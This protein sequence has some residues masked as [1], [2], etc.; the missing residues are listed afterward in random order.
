V[1]RKHKI[2]DG[3]LTGLWEVGENLKS[4]I[5]FA[6]NETSMHRL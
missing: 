2:T 5:Y 6:Q 3:I 1:E 4:F